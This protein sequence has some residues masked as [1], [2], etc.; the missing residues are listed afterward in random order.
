MCSLRGYLVNIKTRLGTLELANPL[1]LASGTAG[2][3]REIA[4]YLDLNRVGAITV[5]GL[6][7]VPCSG[8]PPPRIYES[9]SGVL[10]SI[11]L[12]NKG[13][14]R[15][16]QEDIPFLETLSTRVFVNI[17]GTDEHSYRDVARTLTAI[18]RID[19]IEIN[20][21]CPNVEKGGAS[22]ACSLDSLAS[23][24]GKLRKVVTK[25]LIVKLG[26]MKE[27]IGAVVILLEQLGV[28][29]VSITN[30][31]PALA[32]N[33]S[34]ERLFFSRKTAGLSGPAIKP[35]A[36]RMVYEATQASGIP[37]IGMG[38]ISSGTDAVE[39]LLVGA[40]AVGVGTATLK[41]PAAALEILEGMQSWME[42]RGI[43]RIEEIIGKAR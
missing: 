10:N 39:F 5:K 3:G 18:E 32:V 20:V 12:E 26:P 14:E 6:S 19:G 42:G 2:Y 21:S 17:W 29:A 31:F 40:C 38:G 8:N 25:T 41:N 7:L 33:L 22:F 9:A 1:V 28:D 11:G 37:C 36:L 23:L 35:M 43:E 4:P 34:N 15:F 13:V 24:I 27:D 16:I 30:T